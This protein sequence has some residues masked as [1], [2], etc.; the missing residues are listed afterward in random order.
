[1]SAHCTFPPPPLPSSH[2][3][4]TAQR[5]IKENDGILDSFQAAAGAALSNWVFG[6]AEGE[7]KRLAAANGDTSFR[8]GGQQGVQGEGQ[9]RGA[10]GRECHSPDRPQMPKKCQ[11]CAMAVRATRAARDEKRVPPLPTRRCAGRTRRMFSGMSSTAGTA[12]PSHPAPPSMLLSSCSGSALG[13]WPPAARQPRRRRG[14]RRRPR[15][16][17]R[18]PLPLRRRC[19]HSRLSRRPPTSR[20]TSSRCSS[21]RGRQ[22]QRVGLVAAGARRLPRSSRRR[23]RRR[24]SR[25]IRHLRRHSRRIGPRHPSSHRHTSSPG[26]QLRS[27]LQRSSSTGH[28]PPP[29]SRHAPR[30]PPRRHRHLQRSSSGPFH[31]MASP[32]LIAR[33]CL[34]TAAV[35]QTATTAARLRPHPHSSSSRHPPSSPP[36]RSAPCSRRRSASPCHRL[37]APAGA[38]AQQRSRRSAHHSRR[39]A[40]SSKPLWWCQMQ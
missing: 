8:C 2:C 27:P 24:T 7:E 6:G 34:P 39:Q 18:R 23:P 1:M 15:C 30:L 3:S 33:R 29:S 4:G 12:V 11:L 9:V 17:R 35:T 36:R 22:C 26:A 16:R 37:P 21:R 19:S 25:H 38:A 28:P 40:C 32:S 13:A 20:P 5:A 31:R 14:S 10:L